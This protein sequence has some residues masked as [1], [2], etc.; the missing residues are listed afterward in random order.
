MESRLTSNE[1]K[2]PRLHEDRGTVPRGSSLST[3]WARDGL[4]QARDPPPSPARFL[5]K[6]AARNVELSIF[7][8]S[9]PG[10]IVDRLTPFSHSTGIDTDSMIESTL[11]GGSDLHPTGLHFRE[12]SGN[13]RKAKDLARAGASEISEEEL[14]LVPY[15]RSHST[16]S[17][18][19]VVDDPSPTHVPISAHTVFSRNAAPLSLPQLDKYISTLPPP[20]FP[21]S[22]G[23]NKVMFRPLDRLEATGRSIESLETNFK[24]IPIWRNCNSILR[25]IVNLVLGLTGSS[26]LASFYSL[27]GLFNTVQIFALILTTIV[28]HKG[29]GVVWNDWRQ[30]ILGTIPNILALNF[31]TTLVQSLI[32]L[33]IFMGLSGLLLYAFHTSTAPCKRYSSLEGF[34]QPD[35]SSGRSIVITS[36]LLTVVY[37]PLSTLAVHVITW[38][39]DL[40]AVPN[41]YLNSTTNPPV[42]APL[43]PPDQFR[44]PLD[45]CYTTTMKKNE[46]NFAPLVVISAIMILFALTISYPFSLR[47]LIKQSVPTVD[48]FTEL[49]K[50]RSTNDMNRE[51]QRLLERDQNPLVFLYS[52]FRR[53][54]GTYESLY[55]AMKF[56][57]LLIIAV[58]D[59]NN[60]LFRSFSKTRIAVVRQVLLLVVTVVFFV[61]Q[62]IFSPFL[63]P[64]NNASEWV[65]RLNYVLTSLVA[66][67]VA[68]DVPGK[69]F[70]GGPILYATLVVGST[71]VKATDFA[72]INLAIIQRLVKRLARRIDFSIDVFSPRLD[73]SPSSPHT[74]RRIWQEAITALFLT[75]PECKIPDKQ[76]MVL[77]GKGHVENIKILREVGIVRYNETIMTSHGP[78]ST[79]LSN[80]VEQIQQHFVGPDSYWKSP[81]EH[82]PPGS[83]RFFGNAWWIPFPPTLVIRY[84]DGPLVAL[85]DIPDLELYVK[86]NSDSEVQRRREIRIALRAL[87]G[88]KVYW[89][90]RHVDTEDPTI[91]LCLRGMRYKAQTSTYYEYGTL[92]ISRKG[93][94]IWDGLQLGSGFDVKITYD[95]RINVDGG[96]IGINDDY[97][98]TP[99][100]ARFLRLEPLP[101]SLPIYDRPTDPERL[102]EGYI[103]HERDLRVRQLLVSGETVFRTT[104]ERLTA[105]SA[106]ELGTWWYIFWDDF[107]RRN[108]DTISKLRLNAP[109]FN[110]HYP[111]SIAYT[112]LPR[113]AL[114][115]FL[116]QRGLLNK[117]PKWGDFIDNGFLNKVYTRM[118]DIVFHRSSQA[119]IFHLGYNTHELN[120]ENI[121]IE[122][123]IPVSTLGTGGGTDHDDSAIRPRPIFRWEGILSDPLVKKAP[124]RKLLSKLGVWMGLTPFWRSGS[125]SL[126]VALDVHL[127]GDRYV[128]L[129][130]THEGSES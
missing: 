13:A 4:G 24:A 116:V 65:S 43:G 86:Q 94:L 107:W 37:L 129:E 48:K 128:L 44:D 70:I 2:A 83:T 96:V 32:F 84:D 55:L 34:Q 57:V 45:F 60:C 102:A 3:G 42:V 12:G 100:L 26:A 87:D 67:L 98:L 39:D 50:L 113:A 76:P 22:G 82:L 90:Y 95:K 126:G 29:Y 72:V 118:Y 28:P 122:T 106:T 112:P 109:D 18:Q 130:N 110:P 119:N 81:S 99:A 11:R 19:K 74:R 127:K 125:G 108:S 58:I 75:S 78:D 79:R 105:V 10:S 25:A 97:D 54:W 46:I 21:S 71:E 93:Y 49:G 38:S 121:D 68:L 123:Q 15:S 40:W 14:L 120:M 61:L 17:G 63:D 117:K 101:Y 92:N 91:S 114:E 69:D 64:V 85:K 35:R 27:Q 16:P 66:L 103:K 36:F 6:P 62:W 124:G 115:S 80:L 30:V 8:T 9:P 104:Y 77:R 20:P 111:S 47:M 56:T 5:H 53:D 59:P 23:T 41:P 31:A 88:Q 1:A 73:V 52:G 33:V 51:Y 89:P 7:N